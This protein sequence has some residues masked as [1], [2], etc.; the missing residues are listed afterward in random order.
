MHVP[1]CGHM[2][3]ACVYVED[4][5]VIQRLPWERSTLFREAESLSQNQKGLIP[6]LT[7]FSSPGGPLVSASLELELWAG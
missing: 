6:K 2:K 5:K 1:I 3:N 4:S 7:A